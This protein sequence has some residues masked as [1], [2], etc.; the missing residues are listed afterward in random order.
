MRLNPAD[1]EVPEVSTPDVNIG[2]DNVFVVVVF[3]CLK[4]EKFFALKVS[5]LLLNP[6][7]Y[8]QIIWGIMNRL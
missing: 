5:A 7:L 4:C 2:L 8:K 1:V 3:G 6:D